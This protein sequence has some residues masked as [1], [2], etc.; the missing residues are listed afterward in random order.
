MAAVELRRAVDLTEPYESK[1]LNDTLNSI[2][3]IKK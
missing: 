2:E 1:P 3:N